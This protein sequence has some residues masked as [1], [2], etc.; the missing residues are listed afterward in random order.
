MALTSYFVKQYK[1][2]LKILAACIYACKF[3]VLVEIMKKNPNKKE[4]N[5]P[6]YKLIIVVM[7][8]LR[9]N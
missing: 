1:K 9:L 4:N 8:V 3:I 6:N 5:K 7:Q 2:N